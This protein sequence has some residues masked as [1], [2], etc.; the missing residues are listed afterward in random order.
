MAGWR[1][2]LKFLPLCKLRRL[3]DCPNYPTCLEF[4]GLSAGSPLT[5]LRRS[6]MDEVLIRQRYQFR[7]RFASSIEIRQLLPDPRADPRL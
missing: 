4:N 6:I 7:Y 5:M 3:L 2:G 1:S